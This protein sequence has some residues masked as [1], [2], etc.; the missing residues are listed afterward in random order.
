[1]PSEP[2]GEPA[3]ARPD[4]VSWL[5][6]RCTR[7]APRLHH[8]APVGLLVVGG[9]DHEDL[10]LQAEE[11]TGEGQ[12]RAP[13]PG[14]G[15]G[16][17]LADAGLRVLVGLRDRGVGLVRAG[18]RDALVLVVDPRRRIELGLQAPRAVQRRRAPEL[19]G[20]AHG[21]GDLD[22]RLGADLLEDQRHREDG[23]EVFGPGG[24]HR[25]RMQGR[26]RIAGEVGQEVDPMRRDRVLAEQ[27]LRMR[28]G[29]GRPTLS[30]AHGH[31]RGRPR[32]V[33]GAGGVALRRRLLPDGR[34][35]RGAQPAALLRGRAP[36][37]AR[38]RR[39]VARGAAPARA[40]QPARRRGRGLAPGPRP[41]LR[42]GPRGLR[43]PARARRRRV[44]HRAPA[45]PLPPPARGRASPIPSR[46]RP[47]ASWPPA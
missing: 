28:I 36:G 26:Q 37:G 27:E 44:D 7:G 31:A 33:G 29:H 39:G 3:L 10:A 9:A 45:G 38:A 21:L 22:L 43:A 12:R 14:A 2:V 25:A 42:G 16:R 11:A 15:L 6:E 20:L 23:A 17:Q 30:S 19:V 18:G 32:P 40:A 8:R 13:L 46:S 47:T 1:M 5:G 24:R 34:R 4:S 41:A 35:H